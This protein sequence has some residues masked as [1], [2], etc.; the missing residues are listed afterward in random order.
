[1]P[2]LQLSG[3]SSSIPQNPYR[4]GCILT[5]GGN[6]VKRI[7]KFIALSTISAVLSTGAI[8]A[9]DDHRDD[10]RDDHHDADRRD[11]HHDNHAYVRHDESREGYHMMPEDW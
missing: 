5:G 1:M 9:Q 4:G 10:H 2:C 6:P 11:D 8:F 3:F 7:E